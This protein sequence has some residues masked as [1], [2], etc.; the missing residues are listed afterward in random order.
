MDMPPP[1]VSPALMLF[2]DLWAYYMGMMRMEEG[3][4]P[5]AERHFRAKHDSVFTE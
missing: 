4:F 3:K 1:R 5:R 2:A